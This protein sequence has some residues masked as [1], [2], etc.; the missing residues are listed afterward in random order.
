MK[1]FFAVLNNIELK[2]FDSEY[3]EL[4][5]GVRISNNANVKSHL[6][7]PNIK[8][9][10]GFIETDYVLNS[11]AFLYYEFEDNE[12]VFRGMDNLQILS[13]NLHWVEELLKNSWLIKD[14]CVTCD[15]AFLIDSSNVLS[16]A[17]SLRLQYN[18]TMST[19]DTSTT[20][21]SKQDLMELADINDNIETYL[22]VNK[23]HK[24]DVYMYEKKFSRVGRA[25]VFIK[26]AR[27][28]INLAFRIS[29]YCSALETLFSTDSVELS[30][31]LSERTA[32]FLSDDLNKRKPTTNCILS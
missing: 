26:Q 8:N 23:G 3:L 32:Y 21:F 5:P 12:L 4:V 15:T 22:V 19:G 17:A 1:N 30:H 16:E 31:K 6:L 20:V 14:N 2:D 27:E 9:A 29:N 24:P 28:S 11:S 10:I 7:T 18:H 13:L 25:L